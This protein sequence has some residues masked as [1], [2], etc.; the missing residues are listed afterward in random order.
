MRLFYMILFLS[1]SG[2]YSK[3]YLAQEAEAELFVAVQVSDTTMLNWKTNVCPKKN[4]PN[5]NIHSCCICNS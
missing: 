2:S 4:M 5:K 3:Y 1:N